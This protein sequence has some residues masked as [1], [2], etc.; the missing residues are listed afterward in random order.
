MLYKEFFNISTF[1]SNS[2]TINGINFLKNRFRF[3]WSYWK[4]I[5]NVVIFF[6]NRY[7]KLINIKIN[8]KNRSK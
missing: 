4:T 6:S 7:Y 5:V 1:N 2:K 8:I 3:K